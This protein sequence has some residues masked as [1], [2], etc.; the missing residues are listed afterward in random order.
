MAAEA[1]VAA[2]GGGAEGE[3][4]LQGLWQKMKMAPL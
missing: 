2:E 1:G 3:E 4:D